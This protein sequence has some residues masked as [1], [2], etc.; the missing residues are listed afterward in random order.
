[1]H[2]FL[3]LTFTFALNKASHSLTLISNLL[4]RMARL[5]YYDCNI[6]NLVNG[7][8]IDVPVNVAVM[9]PQTP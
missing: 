3:M 7:L 5:F 1:M 9:H 6:S 2:Y 8:S 4:A